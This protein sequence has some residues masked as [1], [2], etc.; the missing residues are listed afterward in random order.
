MLITFLMTTNNLCS[1]L[2][3]KK[4]NYI[5]AEQIK[6][7]SPNTVSALQPNTLHWALYA[8]QYL[9]TIYK[10]DISHPIGRP[11]RPL[12][13]VKGDL[14]PFHIL[15]KSRLKTTEGG[16]S[17]C[18]EM[19]LDPFAFLGISGF[20]WLTGWQHFTACHPKFLCDRSFSYMYQKAY[21][22]SYVPQ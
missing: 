14:G 1:P 6:S 22:T 15:I 2:L 13:R 19:P 8:V 17:L 18:C 12:K 10:R 16:G 20:L 21:V 7:K 3:T 11:S 5:T 9:A 4:C